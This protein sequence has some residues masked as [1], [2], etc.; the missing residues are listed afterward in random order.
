[1]TSCLFSLKLSP[2]CKGEVLPTSDH[3][4]MGTT[5]TGGGIK[6]TTVWHHHTATRGERVKNILRQMS[7]IRT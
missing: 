7:S 3:I 4:V 2:F 6:L 1:M 5:P